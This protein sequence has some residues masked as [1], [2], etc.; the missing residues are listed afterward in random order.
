MSFAVDGL[1]SGLDTTGLINSLM[2]LE[3]I[4]QATLKTKVSAN[5]TFIT[6]LQG[7][8][9]KAATLATL[10]TD[11]AKPTSLDKHTATTSNSAAATATASAGAGPSSLTMV[12]R[13]LAQAQVAVTA[14]M[15]AWPEDPPVLTVVGGDGTQTQITAASTSLDDIVTAIN[16]SAA[17]VT[18]TKVSAGADGFRLQL[19]SSKTGSTGSF[20]IY[21]GAAVDETK[22]L[23][24]QPG[25]AVVTAAQNAEVVLW[26]GSAAEQVVTSTTNTFDALLPNVAITVAKASTDPVTVTVSRDSAAASKIAEAL[27]GSLN[28]V[29][30][31]ISVKSVVTTSTTGGVTSV[32]GGPF[33]GESAVRSVRQQLLAA[34]T[35]PVGGR[36]PSEM[37]ISITR[38]G[39]VEFDAT[40]F[41]AALASDPDRVQAAL[42]ELAGRVAAAATDASDKVDGQLTLRIASE[43]SVNKRLNTQVLEWDDRL[44]SRRAALE[45]TYAALEVQLS[46]LNAQASYVASQLAGLPTPS[47]SNGS[48]N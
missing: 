20:S 18:A 5:Q 17:G 6:A 45:R 4:P 15:A 46:N 19:T 39:T 38:T 10:A 30:A 11:A 40:K 16:G 31:E 1:I 25:A 33:T 13:S 23:L 34:A 9:A 41:A 12:V 42:S 14:A 3:G 47:S 7:L 44:A 24:T 29:F 27:V 26:A 21:A 28:T 48:N 2:Q 32:N 22:N 36:S 37:G 8:N 43:E 35:M